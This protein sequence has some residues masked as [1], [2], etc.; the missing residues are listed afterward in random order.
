MKLRSRKKNT[1][2]RIKYLKESVPKHVW[3]RVKYTVGRGGRG[4][5]ELKRAQ[6]GGEQK[7]CRIRR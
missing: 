1:N 6:K 3:K 2:I 4:Y 7:S 5:L